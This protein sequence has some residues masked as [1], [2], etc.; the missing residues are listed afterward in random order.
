MDDGRPPRL[1]RAPGERYDDRTGAAAR[2]PGA[3]GGRPGPGEART[4]AG[5]VGVAAIAA[6]GLLALGQV[7]LGPGILAL[8]A[9]TGWAVALALLWGGGMPSPGRRAALAAGL[10]AAAVAAG[11]LGDWAWARSI[12]GTLGPLDYVDQRFGLVLAG[13]SVATAAIVGAVRGR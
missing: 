5:G 6:I 7:D 10:G 3:G 1:E 9:A 4:V 11:L 12:G 8:A 2:E 13:L